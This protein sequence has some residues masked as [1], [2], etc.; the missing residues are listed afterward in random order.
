MTASEGLSREGSPE[1]RLRS[2]EDL[3]RAAKL[4]DS[5][6]AR[7]TTLVVSLI[8][9]GAV[10]LM[11]VWSFAIYAQKDLAIAERANAI[12]AAA[13]AR[14]AEQQALKQKEEVEEL[15]R[16]ATRV[17]GILATSPDRTRFVSDAGYLV[18]ATSNIPITK[19]VEGKI[20]SVAFSPDSTRLAVGS[21]NGLVIYDISG[22]LLAQTSLPAPPTSVLFSPDSGRV[23]VVL[24][25][26]TVLVAAVD[27]RILRTFATNQRLSTAAVSP[28]GRRLLTQSAA[29]G[30]LDVWDMSTG[31]RLITIQGPSEVPILLGFANDGTRIAVTYPNG[32]LL[33]WNI[34]TGLTESRFLL[35][36]PH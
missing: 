10:L 12:L 17:T 4:A 6:S 26:G 29:G 32:E 35:F 22:K 13:E 30:K 36:A 33:T 18:D 5:R 15:Y 16:R 31:Q 9:A 1:E 34:L 2:L 24:L 11:G 19:L 25:N 21:A 27:G 3:V 28:D 8:G 20:S 23:V 14:L 7:R